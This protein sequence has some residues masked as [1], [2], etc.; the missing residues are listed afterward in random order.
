[1]AEPQVT[2]TLPDP[3]PTPPP[4]PSLGPELLALAERAGAAEAAATA[5]SESATTARQLAEATAAELVI[6]REVQAEL[7]ERLAL[8]ET[9]EA[10]PGSSGEEPGPVLAVQ[11]DVPDPEPPP[12]ASAPAPEQIATRP[13]WHRLM[14]G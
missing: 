1:M 13:V 3:D 11:P 4:T 10:L 2:V 8:L 14:F 5:A 7:A 6:A 9:V 12:V